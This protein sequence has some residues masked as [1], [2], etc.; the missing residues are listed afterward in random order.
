[1][2]SLDWADSLDLQDSLNSQDSLDVQDSLVADSSIAIGGKLRLEQS[3]LQS[4]DVFDL[5]GV[6]LGK[7]TAYGFDAAVKMLKTSNVLKSSGIYFLRS[8]STG[9]IQSVR[10]IK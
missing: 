8:H 4:Y 3:R 6:R 5:Q 2:D 10:I 9:K 7:F 1:L